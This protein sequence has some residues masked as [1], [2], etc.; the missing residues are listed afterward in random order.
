[1]KIF[2]LV[3]MAGVLLLCASS[4]QPE[5]ETGIVIDP[6]AEKEVIGK[7]I[8]NSIG[9]ALTKDTVALYE[10]LSGSN[11]FIFH[12]DSGS[13]V[14]DISQIRETAEKIWLNDRFTATGLDIRHLR[15]E[16]SD[17]GDVAWYACIL[18]DLGEWDG[19]PIG[20]YNT[21]WTGVLVKRDSKWVIVQM[22]FSF[23]E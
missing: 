19:N 3:L 1:M 10:S 22:H 21:R 11:L 6:E 9:W 15:I 16:I 5:P 7:V 20:W 12:P 23:A 17:G 4:K 8:Y 14:T 2:Y 18:D 13:T